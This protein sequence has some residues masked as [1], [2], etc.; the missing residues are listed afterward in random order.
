MRHPIRDV[1]VVVPG[2]L[3]SRLK[4]SGR[5]IWGGAGI[6]SAL[7]DPE[8]VLGLQGDG[9]APEPDVA[10]VGLI[11]RLAQFPGLSKIDAYGGLMDWLKD[12]FEL[13]DEVNFV[14]FSYDWRLS[15]TVNARL[16]A[17]RIC[18]ILKTR[19]RTH[20][21]AKFV[22]ICHS[23]GGLVVQ[24]FTD[25]L[26]GGPDTNEVVT[27]GT[28]F[29]GAVKAFGVISEGWPRRLP[30]I[31]SRF[32]RL[33]QTLPSVYELLPRYR[34]I[35]DGSERRRIAPTDLTGEARVDLFQLASSFHDELDRPDARPY[36]RTVIAGTLQPT[37]QFARL[38][39]GKLEIL[40]RWEHQ[41]RWLDERGDGTVP[42]QS[43]APPEWNDDRHAIPFSQTHL[44]L[45]TTDAV[46]RTLFQVLTATPRAEQADERAKLAIEVPD[47]V[48]AG[49]AIEI[50]CEVAEGDGDI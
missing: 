38:Q 22:F 3:G 34:A 1:V 26:G 28:P 36:G 20:P 4:R 23:M 44:A 42:R 12:R 48:P 40:K 15:C 7:V 49:A 16:L 41:G 9:F 47:L 17:N 39:D 29:R 46:F 13:L 50:G 2:I 5:L 37:A 35:I 25:A 31:R 14:P 45:P 6:A 21:S 8:S 30:G 18:P 11:G 10:A 19:R 27:L 32:R 33:A 24:H 43:F